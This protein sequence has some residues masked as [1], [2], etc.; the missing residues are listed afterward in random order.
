MQSD[1]ETAKKVTINEASALL[2]AETTLTDLKACEEKSVEITN[3]PDLNANAVQE[4][5]FAM[6]P[7]RALRSSLHAGAEISSRTR[8]LALR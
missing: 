3:T 8:S 6:W 7:T 5:V 4:L 1:A 2:S